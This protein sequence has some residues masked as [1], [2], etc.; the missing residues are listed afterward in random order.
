MSQHE[1]AFQVG[2]VAQS[3]QQI[4][5]DVAGDHHVAIRGTFHGRRPGIAVRTRGQQRLGIGDERVGDLRIELAAAA[6]AHHRDGAIGAV[7]AAVHF[8]HVGDLRHPHLDRELT[9]RAAR[10][11]AVPVVAF[12]GEGQGTL[13]R[14][15]QPEVGGQG[16][17]RGAVRVD[18]LAE[19]ALGVLEQGGQRLGALHRRFPAGDVAHEEL[20]VRQSRPVDQIGR[21]PHRDVVA[22]PSGVFLGIGMASDPHDQRRVVDGAA[23]FGGQAEPVGQSAGDDRRAQHVFG[24]LTQTQVDGHR[25]RRQHLGSSR[26]CAAAR[27]RDTGRGHGQIVLVGPIGCPVEVRHCRLT[28]KR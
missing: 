1:R 26:W 14:V 17:G 21:G 11:H 22:E 20:H 6:A 5:Q 10:G 19:L 7:E 8:G 25:Q 4:V 24:R 28:P 2:E 27:A 13:D 16:G 15:G 3:D 12:E 23:L 9:A 18:H